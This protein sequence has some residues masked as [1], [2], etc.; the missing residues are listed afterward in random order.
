MTSGGDGIGLS[1]Q[2]TSRPRGERVWVRRRGW[3]EPK[4]TSRVRWKA[5]RYDEQVQA[6]LADASWEQMTSIGLEFCGR[7]SKWAK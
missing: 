3:A 5:L 6:Y 4:G 1:R 2:I 7:K